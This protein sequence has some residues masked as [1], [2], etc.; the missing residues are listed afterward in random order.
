MRTI[1]MRRAL[2][3]VA[4][5][6]TLTLA[7]FT[8]ALATGSTVAH[9]D[10]GPA[11]TVSDGCGSGY[12]EN[13]RGSCIPEPDS[14]PTGIRCEDGTYSHA[15][16][17]QGACSNHGGIDNGSGSSASGGDPTAIILGSF[18]IGGLALGS[19]ALGPLILFGS[20]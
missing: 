4:A 15:E 7:M 9:A 2:A 13:S 3:A 16:T 12:Y 8:G 6:G 17:R 18:A 1:T 10:P 11:H 20:S 14:S 5:T 19:A